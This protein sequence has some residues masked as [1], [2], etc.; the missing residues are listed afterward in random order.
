M[1]SC[2][3]FPSNI[4]IVCIHHDMI[5]YLKSKSYKVWYVSYEQH[6]TCHGVSMPDSV[7]AE[8]TPC[9][10]ITMLI[11]LFQPWC[12]INSLPFYVSLLALFLFLRNRL[13][14]FARCIFF[15]SQ[16][17]AAECLLTICLSWRFPLKNSNF[18]RPKGEIRDKCVGRRWP[19]SFLI[20]PRSRIERK[21]KRYKTECRIKELK[22]NSI[23]I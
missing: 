11:N 16:N 12:L 7:C 14:L 19:K 15:S 2:V 13:W 1:S 9:V 20:G 21:K 18:L 23:L 17:R 8:R 5:L 10:C 6:F 4:C 3:R 22:N